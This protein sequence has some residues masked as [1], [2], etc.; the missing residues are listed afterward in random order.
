VIVII[1]E[2][3]TFDHVFVTYK[4]NKGQSIDNLLS[5]GIVKEDGTPGPNFSLATPLSATDTSAEGYRLNPSA[6]RPIP[7]FRQPLRV[8]I[9]PPPS[10]TWLPPKRSRTGSPTTT[11]S[12]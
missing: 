6:K 12:T 4:P 8:D 1:G 9:R 10:P 3:W 2:E 7:C 5:K 11:M